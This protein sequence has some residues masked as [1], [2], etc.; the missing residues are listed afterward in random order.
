LALTYKRKRDVEMEEV[1]KAQRLEIR[2]NQVSPMMIDSASSSPARSGDR[3]DNH[4]DLMHNPASPA[5]KKISLKELMARKKDSTTDSTSDNLYSKIGLSPELSITRIA[6]ETPEAIEKST[7]NGYFPVVPFAFVGKA[8]DIPEYDSYV[9]EMVVSES[10]YVEPR[11]LVKTDYRDP[12]TINRGVNNR[13]SSGGESAEEGEMRESPAKQIEK[14]V[15]SDR[16]REDSRQ[17]IQRRNSRNQS[18]SP[19]RAAQ[20]DRGSNRNSNRSN[21]ATSRGNS[22]SS[23]IK[24][25]RM[26]FPPNNFHQQRNQQPPSFDYSSRGRGRGGGYSGANDRGGYNGAG[27]RGYGYAQGPGYDQAGGYDRYDSGGAANRRYDRPSYDDHFVGGRGDF[28]GGG[29][30]RGRGDFGRGRGDYGRGGF[31]RGIF[32]TWS[33]MNRSETADGLQ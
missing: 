5:K 18:M 23:P 30:G 19:V 17:S 6:E 1:R 3:S 22:P 12:S 25:K 4:E 28:R 24:D 10:V 29:R 32:L 31:G 14:K 27:D 7:D 33:L 16:G 13:M 8:D 26:S 15:S 20:G 11:I 2:E 21:S 9:E